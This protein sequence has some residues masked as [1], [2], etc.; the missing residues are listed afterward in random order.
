MADRRRRVSRASGDSP[1]PVAAWPAAASTGGSGSVVATLPSPSPAAE[2]L[3]TRAM[4]RTLLVRG[5]T[6]D[7]AANLTAFLAGL[8]LGERPWTLNQ[9]NRL[10]FLRELVRTGRFGGT[11]GDRVH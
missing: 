3:A 8:T 7:E 6:P 9:V 5:L 10:L 2:P 1:R 11:D 4:Y